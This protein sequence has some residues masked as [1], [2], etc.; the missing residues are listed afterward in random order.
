MK[1][2]RHISLTGSCQSVS[3]EFQIQPIPGQSKYDKLSG[4]IKSG[5]IRIPTFQRHVVWEPQE[6]AKLIDSILKGYPV[7]T[8]VFWR[9]Q[10]KLPNVRSIGGV[11][12]SDG[13]EG[14]FVQYV[15]D[16]QQRLSSMFAII[17]GVTL[18][19]Y[20]K[21]I[22]YKDIFVNLETSADSDNIVSAEKP[23]EAYITVHDLLHKD[24]YELY[25]EYSEHL[26]NIASFQN[27]I[28]NYLFPTITI[29]GYP[30]DKAVD[31]FSRINTT[32]KTLTLFDI[33]AATTYDEESFDLR[34]KNEELQ[35]RLA[36]VFYEIPK[37][38]ILQCVSVNIKKKCTRKAILE[39]TKDDMGKEWE[40]TALAIRKAIDHFRMSYNIPSWRLL[41]YP[42]LIVPF[43][44][45]FR[46]NKKEPTVRQVKYLR[47]YFWRAALTSRFTSSVENKLASDCRL[48]DEVMEGKRPEYGKEF[49]VALSEKDVQD[50][51]FHVGDAVNNAVLCVLA[52]MKP[53]SFKNGDDVNLGAANL[54][55]SNSRNYHHFFPKAFLKKQ[56]VNANMFNLISNITFIG[57]ELNKEIGA[58]A[59]SE[60]MREFS[61][62]N[63]DLTN[64]MKTHLI[65]DLAEYGIWNDDYDKFI[66]MRSALIW[67]NLKAI[68]DPE[69]VQDA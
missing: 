57:A 55:K 23:R 27:S 53:Q 59:P 58:R 2:K 11:K 20:N 10:K 43:S 7:G 36:D 47:E 5:V 24:V 1:V 18:K 19:R 25:E 56:G 9:T 51:R 69:N 12:L 48:M 67:N 39:L 38:Q 63:P 66:K 61:E 54:A 3:T 65:G 35:E 33:M 60:Y 44:Y 8:L 13:N 15:L 29:D 14:G 46:E 16:G 4:D 17:E 42:A 28:R 31:I 49:R 6:S 64:T 34:D 41:P 30:I 32:G 50:L 45:F 68:F 52:S 22:D 21:E 62:E 37:A 40:A 26:K